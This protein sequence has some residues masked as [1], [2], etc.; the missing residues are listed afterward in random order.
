MACTRRHSGIPNAC[1]RRGVSGSVPTPPAP[2]RVI[3]DIAHW[4]HPVKDVFTN[5]KLSLQRVTFKGG[6]ATFRVA[7]PFDPQI[8]R[9]WVGQVRHPQA[10]SS[11]R[12]LRVGF[13]YSAMANSSPSRLPGMGL[14]QR[15]SAW[16][17]MFTSSRS[18]G[19]TCQVPPQRIFGP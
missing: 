6:H 15:R 13:A 8:R 18:A 5:Y 1:T 2:T 19:G 12:P 4:Q 3:D 16:I 10:A 7:F 9:L 14:F 17:H 11:E